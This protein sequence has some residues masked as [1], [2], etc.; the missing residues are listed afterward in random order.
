MNDFQIKDN[1]TPVVSALA[2]LIEASAGF[3]FSLHI[4]TYH[5]RGIL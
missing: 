1:E 3:Q 4:V 2:F 5:V